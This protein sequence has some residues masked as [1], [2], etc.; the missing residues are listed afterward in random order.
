M[1]KIETVD[2]ADATGE[3]IDSL[4]SIGWTDKDIYDALTHGAGMIAQSA[5]Y[6]ALAK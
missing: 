5:I 2:P 6:N 3:R 4:R 1:F